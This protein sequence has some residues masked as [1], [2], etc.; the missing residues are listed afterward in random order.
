M[1]NYNVINKPSRKNTTQGTYNVWRERTKWTDTYFDSNK[2]ANV[3][4]YAIRSNRLTDA[5]K[6]NIKEQVVV[7][8]QRN[9]S[10]ALEMDAVNKEKD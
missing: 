8:I 5:E 9:E 3:R 2:L 7:N 10:V 4:R 1:R 6:D